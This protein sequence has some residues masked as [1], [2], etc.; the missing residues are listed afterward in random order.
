MKRYFTY[1]TIMTLALMILGGCASKKNQL[2][3]QEK[4][5]EHAAFEMP[6]EIIRYSRGSCYGKCPVYTLQLFSDGKVILVGKQNMN[7]IG[8]YEYDLN[9]D[10]MQ[11]LTELLQKTDFNAMKDD[12]TGNIAD[13]PHVDLAV[14]TSDV[15]KKIGGNWQ[16]PEELTTVFEALNQYVQSEKWMPVKEKPILHLQSSSIIPDRIIVNLRDGMDGE[17]WVRKY[18]AFSGAIVKRVSPRMQLWVMTYDMYTIHPMEMLQK[19]KSDTDVVTAEFDKNLEMRGG[20][21]GH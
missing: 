11:A 4:N 2:K 7:H 13:L 6:K 10:E 19:I 8:M 21:R 5:M 16:F 9:E 12:Y 3:A 15:Q 18:N 1:G 14:T 20:S 17:D